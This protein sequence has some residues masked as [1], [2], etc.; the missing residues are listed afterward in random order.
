MQDANEILKA[1]DY[2]VS[3]RLVEQS[4]NIESLINGKIDEKIKHKFE[5]T[6]SQ[7]KVRYYSHIKQARKPIPIK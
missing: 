5:V 4:G 3:Q 7:L 6:L 1:L 2:I